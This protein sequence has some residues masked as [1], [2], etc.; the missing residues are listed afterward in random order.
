MFLSCFSFIWWKISVRDNVDSLAYV[1][2]A[3]SL[4]G[5]MSRV[6]GEIAG[7]KGGLFSVLDFFVLLFSF[8]CLGRL[9]FLSGLERF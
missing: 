5:G 3:A 4:C 1:V 9:G 8:V 6:R 2:E 7:C